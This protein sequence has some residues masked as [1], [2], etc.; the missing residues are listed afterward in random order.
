MQRSNRNAI[1]K[2]TNPYLTWSGSTIILEVIFQSSLNAA[3]RETLW[4]I[5]SLSKHMTLVTR[6]LW[7]SHFPK[8]K[9]N[10]S[11]KT[12]REAGGRKG[13][14]EPAAAAAVPRGM[15]RRVI[16]DPPATP[17]PAR[18]SPERDPRPHKP[19]NRRD[20][21][22]QIA[23][24]IEGWRCVMQACVRCARWP[25]SD[26]RSDRWQLWQRSHSDSL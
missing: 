12:R 15:R 21:A 7:T 11:R 17:R 20:R 3:R 16:Y 1:N 23:V 14:A 24:P 26:G 18:P 9:V 4:S 2:S 19:E 6:Q 5:N 13:S 22:R 8:I 25:C 10:T